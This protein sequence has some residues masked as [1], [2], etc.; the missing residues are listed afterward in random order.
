M[1][2]DIIVIK[3]MLGF[4]KLYLVYILVKELKKN[5][6][7][8]IYLYI[9]DISGNGVVICLMVLE[10]GVDIIDVVLEF[11]VGFIS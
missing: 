3:D 5:V 9:Y 10:V 7:V 2:V 6:K 4:F 8:L 11:M 1:G